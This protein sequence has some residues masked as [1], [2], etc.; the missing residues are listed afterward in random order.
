MNNKKHSSVTSG[1]NELS[2][3]P[4]ER[5]IIFFEG[6][7]S[8]IKPCPSGHP[9]IG[10]GHKVIEKNGKQTVNKEQALSILKD[11]IAT[12]KTYLSQSL[13]DVTLKPH[14]QE[15]LISLV[16]N[17]GIGNFNKSKLKKH[18]L[19]GDFFKASIEFLDITKC[20]GKVSSGLF[21]RRN[22]EQDL[23]LYGWNHDKYT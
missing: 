19:T 5:L 23:F 20:N 22:I 2:I 1:Q 18:L 16:Y 11:D 12:I 17:W 13:K 15:A 4:L 6:F 21:K 9:T 7:N 8:T 3:S 10:Y 14:Q